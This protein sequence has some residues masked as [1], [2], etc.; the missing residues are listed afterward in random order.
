M[1]KPIL[2][3]LNYLLYTVVLSLACN[4]YAITRILARSGSAQIP[5]SILL[6]LLLLL[7]YL[8]IHIFPIFFPLRPKTGRLKACCDGSGLLILFLNSTVCSVSFFLCGCFGLLPTGTPV[9]EP[10]LWIVNSLLAVLLEALIFWNGIIRVYTSSLQLGVRIRV[11]G[12]A[13]GMIPIAH[14]VALGIIIRTVTREV[15]FENEKILLNESRR[16]EQICA[17][18]YP[19]LMVHGVFFRD[20]RYFNYWGR[21][22]KELEAN[23]A[24]VFYGN[25]QS[26]ASVSDSGREI[27]NRILQIIKETG[28]EKVNIIA[29]SKGGLDARAA[30]QL[31]GIA[32][33]VASL[34]TVSTPHRGCE[35]ADYL[36]TRIPAKQQAA[37]AKAYN[38]AL[39]K[40][41]DPDPDFLGAVGD[42]TASACLEFNKRTPDIPSVY[43]Q[44]VGSRL[45]R[46][47][48]GRFPLN[49]TYMLAKHFDGANDGLVGYGSFP[50][51]SEYRLL[52]VKGTRGI[53]HGDMIDLNRENLPEFDVREFYVQLV[54]DL[55]VRGF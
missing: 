35:F 37:V 19:I 38:A 30:L 50:W 25:H 29:H 41:G 10:G 26:A 27:G 21:I 31:P 5:A 42:L 17:T 24:R 46:A 40:V 18:K 44:S 53:S 2:K 54:A 47:M 28:C 20:F 12:I 6:W 14:L 8:W 55:K 15:S 51:G 48:G 49:F 13:C 33:H 1:K 23:G 11:I 7:L 16:E 32:E 9:A 52:T 45:S 22:P 36:L 39:K 34:T 43:Y 4:L 3:L